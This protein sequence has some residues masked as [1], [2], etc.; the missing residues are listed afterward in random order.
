LIHP[1]DAKSAFVLPARVVKVR[2]GDVDGLA[3]SCVADHDISDPPFFL[4]WA[5]FCPAPPFPPY[6]RRYILRAR[7]AQFQHQ[8]LIETGLFRVRR[9]CLPAIST[10]NGAREFIF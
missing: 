7:D 10:A 4:C 6:I 2:S 5:P 1:G 9:F 8:S 3:Q